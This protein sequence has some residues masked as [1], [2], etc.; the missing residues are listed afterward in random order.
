MTGAPRESKT[1][2]V[3]GAREA[4]DRYLERRRRR[5]EGYVEVPID[6]LARLAV[7]DGPKGR[8]C[9]L[10]GASGTGSA[11]P[12][13]TFCLLAAP[14]E[15]V[16]EFPEVLDQK[17]G[18]PPRYWVDGVGAYTL[19]ELH[20][21]LS[22]E[23]PLVR[24]GAENSEDPVAD[25]VEVVAQNGVARVPGVAL[26][27]AAPEESGSGCLVENE[28]HE[29]RG[30]R[31]LVNVES[32]REAARVGLALAGVGIKFQGQSRVKVWH[33]ATRRG[34]VWVGNALGVELTPAEAEP[35]PD[36]QRSE[37]VRT[38]LDFIPAT[39]SVA[40][41]ELAAIEVQEV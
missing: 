6:V 34:A 22:E 18:S 20:A 27:P 23:L 8:R 38:L 17:P 28:L 32:A 3:S 24:L 2:A 25:S 40:F 36:V 13:E 26:A 19:P 29:F 4:A 39:S 41:S 5:T 12:H 1:V 33:V 31:F 16:L 35:M 10:C 11:V 37:E 7:S 9:D 30:R 15:G 14:A 21:F